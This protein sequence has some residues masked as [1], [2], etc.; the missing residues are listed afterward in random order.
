MKLPRWSLWLA[1]G[2]LLAFSAPSAVS[3][4]S[5]DPGPAVHSGAIAPPPWHLLNPLPCAGDTVVLVMMGFEPT[6][7]D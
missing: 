2:A 6:A 1:L 7:C 4:G 3:A 5:I